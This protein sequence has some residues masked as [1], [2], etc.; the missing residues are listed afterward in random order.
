MEDVTESI[1]LNETDN[2]LRDVE[3]KKLLYQLEKDQKKGKLLF[4]STDNFIV[5]YKDIPT[6]YRKS[7]SWLDTHPKS[8]ADFLEIKLKSAIN[9]FQLD[10]PQNIQVVEAK[11]GFILSSQG[12]YTDNTKGVLSFK[13]WE[14]TKFSHVYSNRRRQEG[15]KEPI[16]YQS[17]IHEAIGHGVLMNNFLTEEAVNAIGE[18]AGLSFIK[19]GLAVY[20]EYYLSG[21]DTHDYLRSMMEYHARMQLSNL[22]WDLKI[23]NLTKKQIKKRVQ[24]VGFVGF[25]I[26]GVFSLSNK[27]LS[28]SSI[29]SNNKEE[30]NS[31]FG[32]YYRGGS[33]V[34]YFID[35][36]GMSTFKNWT[37]SLN[38]K[39]FYVSLEEV[40]RKSIKDI[41]QE[42]RDDVLTEKLFNNP[43][44][45]D[46]ERKLTED[47]KQKRLNERKD[48]FHLYKQYS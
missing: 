34:K 2:N 1:A 36:Y 43:I 18:N 20:A 44:I 37:K 47:Q 31:F 25:S 9:H 14:N 3:R 10:P 46:E 6:I 39:N 32:K 27:D 8:L 48:I 41:E 28:P 23:D 11:K 40:S 19:E 21:L 33:F 38:T 35:R 13:E 17:A 12:Q 30:L 24:K 42:W 5:I 22:D 7:G 15:F 16:I 4:A 45:E 29:N 26:A